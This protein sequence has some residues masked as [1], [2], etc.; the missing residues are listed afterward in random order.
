M[1][2]RLRAIAKKKAE[3]K[4]AVDAPDVESGEVA[5]SS[6]LGYTTPG[7]SK[8][9]SEDDYH[10]GPGASSSKLKV[11]LEHSP[12]VYAYRLLNPEPPTPAQAFGKLVHAMVLE[13]E[14]VSEKFAFSPSFNRRESGKSD[15]LVW[16]FKQ[17]GKIII[18]PDDVE[19]AQAM[20]K[21]LTEHETVGRLLDNI[22]VE[23]SVFWWYQSPVDDDDREYREYLKIRPDILNLTRPIIADIKTTDDAS[24]EGFARAVMKYR[25]HFS[26][27]M[28]LEGVNQCDQIMTAT[29]YR[30]LNFILI[31]VEK[32]PPYQV[33]IYNLPGDVLN[34]GLQQFRVAMQR[35]HDA[36]QSGFP[37]MSPEIRDIKLPAWADKIIDV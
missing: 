18:S 5:K 17:K 23:S 31:A 19:H 13:P 30:Y 12:A 15:K 4:A 36:R 10:N 22:I 21:N 24:P 26:A 37:S 27:A 33:A 25:Y 28:Y 2:R 8:Y 1:S 14:T 16:E 6:Q 34:L 29:D 35:L 3:S 32:T 9:L 20:V 11:L 7:W